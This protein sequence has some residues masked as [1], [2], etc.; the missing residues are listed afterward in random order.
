MVIY[1]LQFDNDIQRLLTGI[2]T[3]ESADTKAH[4]Y[5]TVEVVENCL[6]LIKVKAVAKQ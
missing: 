1:I 6:S 5:S 2:I 4:I 3:D